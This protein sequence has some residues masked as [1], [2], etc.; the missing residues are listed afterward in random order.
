MLYLLVIIKKDS[1][2]TTKNNLKVYFIFKLSNLLILV[3]IS[4][5]CIDM[6]QI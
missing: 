4:F 5:P 1:N 2:E 3:L 6:I